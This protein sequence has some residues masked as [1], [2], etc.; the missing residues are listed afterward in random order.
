MT[1][2]A[3]RCLARS[4]TTAEED[5]TIRV[6]CILYGYKIRTFMASIT[7]WLL[8]A[9][10]AGTPEVILPSFIFSGVW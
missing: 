3:N 1:A 7:E 5:L 10:T 6:R 2:I 8:A 4:L 9:L